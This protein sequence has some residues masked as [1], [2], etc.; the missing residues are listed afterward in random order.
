MVGF[1]K[2][3]EQEEQPVLWGRTGHRRESRFKGPAA[4]C[5]LS[6]AAADVSPTRHFTRH[7]FLSCSS[8][9]HTTPAL[10]CAVAFET[11]TGERNSAPRVTEIEGE[12][13]W[14]LS[15]LVILSLFCSLA[16]SPPPLFRVRRWRR[17]AMFRLGGDYCQVLFFFFFSSH[18]VLMSMPPQLHGLT[19]V[20]SPSVSLLQQEVVSASFTHQSVRRAHGLR[21]AAHSTL[22]TQ[23][24]TAL[25]PQVSPSACFYWV[26]CLV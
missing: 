23:P 16:R 1:R 9:S 5:D 3:R 24:P 6:L 7:L 11:A 2:V 13:Q 26:Y 15:R 10:T 18:H 12:A 25:S 21:S 4:T 14:P 17:C 22:F 8:R 20:F 19:P